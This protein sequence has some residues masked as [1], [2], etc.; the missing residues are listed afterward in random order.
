MKRKLY[1]K[2]LVNKPGK[3]IVLAV[4]KED[5]E[6]EFSQFN[7]SYTFQVIEGEMKLHIQKETINLN[8]GQLFS[9]YEN[10]NY[11]LTTAE[12]TMFLLTTVNAG[13]H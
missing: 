5:V 6:I 9:Y 13:K 11:S 10:S 4:I 1:S 7:D 12:K 8:E 3:Q 2:I